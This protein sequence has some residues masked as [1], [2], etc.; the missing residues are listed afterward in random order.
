MPPAL[1]AKRVERL[2]RVFGLLVAHPDGLAIDD[3]C[4]ATGLSGRDLRN[5]LAVFMNR[6]LPATHDLALTDG[7]GIEFFTESG[8]E[9]VS[10]EAAR[11]RI[12]SSAPLAELGLEYFAADVLG[13]LYRAASDLSALEPDNE[14]LAGAVRR[15]AQ[16][17]LTGI[18]SAT[19]YGGETAG[20]LRQAAIARRRVRI[21]Y[22]RAWRPGAGTRVIEPYRV[23]STRRGFEV[24]AGPLDDQGEIRTFLVSGIRS[25]EVLGESFERP[26]DVETAIERSR[27]LTTVRLV[28]PRDLMWV[29]D[30]FAERSAVLRADEDAEIEAQVLPPVADRVGLMLT[31]AGP[32]AFV[33]SPQTLAD[34]GVETA[35]RL[36]AHHGLL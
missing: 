31:I 27:R 12:T 36:L 34:A 19:P 9:T 35:S 5:D 18:D 11:V 20:A 28:V 13:P 10:T 26:D 3:L 15:M 2:A 4:Q 6:D 8:L 24:D 30:R 22:W 21:D 14:V 7:I 25:F 32:E 17:L 1:Y 33:V 16:T 23:V 29:V